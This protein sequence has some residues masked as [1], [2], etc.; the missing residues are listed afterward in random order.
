MTKEYPPTLL[1]QISNLPKRSIESRTAFNTSLGFVTSQQ[2][3]MALPP[4]EQ[5][6][7][8]VSR[9]LISSQYC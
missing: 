4:L 3:E 6:I 9:A 7:S 2:V 8:T 1:I 5:I